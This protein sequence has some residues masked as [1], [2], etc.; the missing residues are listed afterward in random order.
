MGGSDAGKTASLTLLL[1]LIGTAPFLAAAQAPASIAF[2]LPGNALLL[3]FAFLTAALT[4]LFDSSPISVR[5][6]GLPLG[7]TAALA[8]FAGAQLLPFPEGFLRAVASA[9][10]TIYHEAIETLRAFGAK[11]V[12]SARVTIAP[13]ETAD[14]LLLI[15]AAAAVF[16]CSATLL[17]TRANRRV[18]TAVLLASAALQS[19]W[20]FRGPALR[21]KASTPVA[22]ESLAA[23]LEIALATA[24][25]VLWA[26]VLTGRDRSGDAVERS[27]RLER[28]LPALVA[29]ALVWALFAAAIV[30]TEWRASL[31]SAAATT[32]LVAAAGVLRLLTRNAR[33]AARIAGLSFVIGCVALAVWGGA[34]DR[35]LGGPAASHRA[36]LR[37]AS[38]GAWRQFPLVGSGLGAYREAFRRVQSEAIR[39][40]VDR[41]PDDL[42]SLAVTGGLVG[43]CLAATLFLSLPLLSLERWSRQRHREE[44]AFALGGF[45]AL[46]S[47]IL[48]GLIGSGFSSPA[49]VL[50]LAGVQG[51]AWAAGAKIK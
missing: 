14:A 1:L 5:A 11:T 42:R 30:R 21:S 26:E 20:L 35:R 43:V 18:F 34:L 37:Q 36:A 38:V 7:T 49:V 28:R 19:L 33:R 15:I 12:P 41:G 50:T 13:T 8:L 23:F 6:I 31:L 39:E 2:S 44:S 51:A 47:L 10:V 40:R 4:F 17:A 29:R 22:P 48:H 45:G 27:E 24:F 16:F 3:F 46:A 25:G 32:I 9:N